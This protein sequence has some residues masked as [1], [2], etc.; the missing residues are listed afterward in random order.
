MLKLTAK[1]DYDL[2]SIYKRYRQKAFQKHKERQKISGEILN[3]FGPDLVIA[4]LVCDLG[5]RVKFSDSDEW[6]QNYRNLPAI[7]PQTFEEEHKLTIIDASGTSICY[8][9]FEHF[10]KHLKHLLV[11]SNPQIEDKELA[12]LLLE[13][14]VPKLHVTGVDYLGKLDSEQKEHIL[15]LVDDQQNEESK[16]DTECSE[17][18]NSNKA[19]N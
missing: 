14:Y 7:L 19:H 6:I 2:E 3:R 1:K 16:I 11:E 13:D 12:C 4:R 18:E 9:A 17:T 15:K 10:R 5:G 8:E